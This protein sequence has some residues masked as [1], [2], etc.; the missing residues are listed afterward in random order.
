MYKAYTIKSY[1]CKQVSPGKGYIKYLLEDEMGNQRAVSAMAKLGRIKKIKSVHPIHFRE[2]P[3]ID[4]L[5]KAEIKDTI[6]VDFSEFNKRHPRVA[7]NK[8]RT[9]DTS[10]YREF[11]G[12]QT[13]ATLDTFSFEPLRLLQLFIISLVG[14]AILMALKSFF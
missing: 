3:L 10:V 11:K 14:L 9:L 5:A 7:S 8:K 2:T 13:N 4:A 6:V 12:N 1:K